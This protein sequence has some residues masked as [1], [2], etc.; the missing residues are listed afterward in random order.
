MVEKVGT[1][2]VGGIDCEVKVDDHGDYVVVYSTAA[3]SETPIPGSQVK[4]QK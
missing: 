2:Q 1:Y 4:I 3:D